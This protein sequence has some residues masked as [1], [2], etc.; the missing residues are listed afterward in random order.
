VHDT[1]TFWP[2]VATGNQWENWVTEQ[3][4]QVLTRSLWLW[5]FI[6]IVGSQTHRR[7]QHQRCTFDCQ[8]RLTETTH[9]VR[10]HAIWATTSNWRGLQDGER[11]SCVLRPLQHSI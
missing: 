10:L 3:H 2:A 1:A 11:A 7:R 9:N 8:V 6:V 4:C 5:A